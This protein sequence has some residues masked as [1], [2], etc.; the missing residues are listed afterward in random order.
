M[1]PLFPDLLEPTSPETPLSDRIPEGKPRLLKANRQQWFFRATTMEDLLPPD[2]IA[3][4]IWSVVE[5]LELPGFLAEI[6]SVEGHEGAPAI[7]PHLLLAVWVY[8]FSEGVGSARAVDRLCDQHDGYRWILG[9]VTVNYHTLSDFRGRNPAAMEDLFAEILAGLD[10]AGLV[11]LEQVAQ[12]GMRVRAS[13]GAASFRRQPT[14]QHSLE[15]AALRVR[16]LA[17]ELEAPD[18]T[19]QPDAPSTRQR[20]AALRAARD[21]QRRL[22][23]AMDELAKV[24]ETRGKDPDEARVSTTDPECRVMK[25]ADGGFRPAFNVQFATSCA[26]QVI[27]GVDVSNQG[28]DRG[29]L[30]PMLDQLKRRHGKL[31]TELLVDGGYAAHAAIEEATTRGIV[32]YAPVRQSTKNSTHEPHDGDSAAIVE[33]RKR[34]DSERAREIYPLRAA[35]AE[36]VNALARLRSVTQLRLRGLEKVR[37]FALLIAITHNIFRWRS[38]APAVV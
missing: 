25:M 16:H 12:D 19:P 5:P 36:C 34:M 15:L 21:Q 33:W 13:A 28:T 29:Q 1:S 2:H 3:R 6:R 9:G 20:A 4:A 17:Q 22:T 38:L 27:L 24:R 8:A 26:N 35:T 37:S 30:V 10:Q 7:D 11:D 32:V 31:P 14:V 23:K 18:T